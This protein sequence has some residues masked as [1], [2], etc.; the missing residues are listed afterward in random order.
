[1]GTNKACSV[2]GFVLLLSFFAVRVE[3]QFNNAWIDYNKTYYKFSLGQDGL[4]RITGGV[5]KAAGLGSNPAESFQLWHNGKE[6]PIYTSIASGL[7]NDDD[8]I[9]FFGQINDGKSDAP[10]YNNPAFQLSDKWSLYTDTAAYFLTVNTASVNLR[11]SEAVNTVASNTLTP[12]PYFMHTLERNFKDQLNPGFASVV[13][14][15]IYSSS[16]DNG[17]GWSSRNIQP[18]TPLVEQ[19]NNLFVAS[20]GPDPVLKIAAFG[21]AP[22]V[23][24]VRVAINGS[25]LLERRMDLFNAAVQEVGFPIGLIGRAVDTIR[26]S[27]TSAV[28]TDRMTLAKY[29]LVYPRTFNFGGSPLF[30][31]T[32]PASSVGNYLEINGFASDNQPPVLYNLTDKQRYVGILDAVGQIKYA[33]PAGGIRQFVLMNAAGQMRM[34]SN[35]QQKNFKNF[36]NPALQGDFLLITHA[37][38]RTSNVGDPIL[39]YKSYRES[40]SGGAHKVG[41][42]DIDELEDQFAWGIKKHP[43]AIKNFIAFA[44]QQF[45]TIPKQLLLV[46]KGVTYDQYRINESR[47]TAA[48]L[49]L[50]PTFGSPGSDNILVSDGNDPTPEIPVGRL[51]VTSGDEIIVYLNKVKQHEQALRSPEQT[52]AAKAWMKKV[53]HVIGGGDPYLQGVI[54]GYMGTAKSIIQDTLFGAQVSTFEKLTP[55]GIEQANSGLLGNLIGEGLGLITYFGH[56]SAN[57][58]E[59]NLDDPIIFSNSGKYPLFLANGCNAGNFFIY[60]SLRLTSGKRSISENY[61]LTPDKGSIGFLASTHYGIVNYLNLYTFSLYTRLATSNYGSS[62]GELQQK[63]LQDVMQKGGPTDFYNIITMEQCLLNGDPAVRLFAQEFPDYVVE[64]TTVGVSPTPVSMT[65][66]KFDV[67]VKVVNIGRA[68]VDSVPIRISHELPDAT[69][70]TIYEGKIPRLFF[71]D[72]ILIPVKMDAARYKGQNKII[73]QVNPDGLLRETSLANNAVVRTFLISEDN[74]RP[75]YPYPFAI[76]GTQAVVLKASVGKFTNVPGDYTVELDTTALFNSSGKISQTISSSGGMLE[77]M[78]QIQ[79]KDST[80]YY[81]RVAQKPESG[82]A[83]NWASSSFVYLSGSDRGWNQSHFFQQNGNLK[84]DLTFNQDRELGFTNQQH[85]Y[86]VNTALLPNVANAIFNDQVNIIPLICAQLYGSFQ[87]GMVD[88]RLGK[89]LKNAYQNNSGRFKSDFNQVCSP[90]LANAFWF[91]YNNPVSRKNMM[92]M[93]DSVPSGTLIV[94]MNLAN[95]TSRFDDIAVWQND[96]LLNGKGNSLYHKMKMLG[97]HLVDSLTRKLPFLFVAQKNGNNVWEVIDQQVGAQVNSILKFAGQY[98]SLGT[99]GVEETGLIGPAKNWKN[100]RWKGVSRDLS[101]KD[102]VVHSI[103]GVRKD[104]SE[105]RLF[106]TSSLFM[107]SS[108]NQIDATVFPY[109]KIKRLYKD[110]AWNTPWQPGYLQVIYEEVPEGG[111]VSQG[112]VIWQDSIAVGA[113]VK[114]NVAFKNI[115]DVPFDSLKV[116]VGV[117]DAGNQTKLVLDTLKKPLQPGDTIQL[118][119]TLNTENLKGSNAVLVNFNPGDAQ[120]EQFQF[121]NYLLKGIYVGPDVTAPDLDVTFD[122]MHIVNRDIVSSKPEI[123]MTLRDDSKYLALNDT[124]L[125]EV[126]LKYPDGTLKQVKFDKDTLQFIPAEINNAGSENLAKVLFKPHLTTD[127][128][129]E[130]SVQAKDRS[131]NLSGALAYNIAFEV[132]NKPMIT[133]MLNYPNPFTTSTAFVFTLTGSVLPTQMRIQILTVTGKIVREI[134][135]QELGPIQIGQNITSYK[136]DG[137]DQFGQQ[138]ANGVYLYRVNAEING[139]SVEKFSRD[140]QNTD[141]YF[142]SGYGKM[143]LMR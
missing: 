103:V 137:R 35:F 16:F 78:P 96:T 112:T 140:G 115:S 15:Y 110:T 101:Q 118:N 39:L 107:D 85:N 54:N 123:L 124:S 37:S 38:L 74:I 109:L 30:S 6:V 7:F 86:R 34:V 83:L 63:A 47:S 26:V 72:S 105:E 27:N 10:L 139:R 79:L 32:L 36:V 57:S 62:I 104:F 53:A 33:L 133:N 59:Y 5:L 135:A 128:V 42:F 90:L 13:G 25:L 88:L 8:F 97:F 71:A 70:D 125:F 64:E 29:E 119:Y 4:Y 121:N 95:A 67:K 31:F 92:D 61:I 102:E 81:W 68:V 58:M 99:S 45:T 41:I 114:V 142:K 17:E 66:S 73:V 117:I 130:L 138:L 51:S 12:E 116:W 49:N 2:L 129:Y 22:N 127:G 93:F 82:A 46:G 1:M 43:L 48:K 76:V 9:E 84:T 132:I 143:Y 136:W 50:I 3:A 11:I 106:E 77:Y 28:S 100:I 98:S 80:V 23:R 131:N 44:K 94:M 91:G 89:P 108:I 65:D 87:I 69:V 60:D 75:V 120:P 111:L 14:V 126:R 21:N 113:P 18:A 141:R 55:A 134:T 19:Q 20:A 122:G 52:I 24:A 40:T 56:S